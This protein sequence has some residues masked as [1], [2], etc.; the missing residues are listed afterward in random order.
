MTAAAAL[1]DVAPPLTAD[2]LVLRSWRVDDADEVVALADDAET[3]RWSPSLRLVDDHASALAWIARRLERRTDWA[4]CDAAS[5]RL[6][7]RIGLHHHDADDRSAE[8][9]YGVSPRYRRRGVARRA[10]QAVSAYAFSPVEEAGLGLHRLALEHAVG[11]VGSCRTASACGYAFEG[12]AREV[13]RDGSG[14]FDD[15]HLHGRLATDPPGPLVQVVPPE[16]VE[17]AAGAYQLTVP[18][19][20][21]DAADVLAACAD[22]EIRRWN[23]GPATMADARAWCARRGDW[24]RGDHASWLVRAATS[25]ELVGSVSL[26]EVDAANSSCEVGYWV[27][28]PARGRGAATASIAAAARF[29]FDALGL[30]R[31]EIFHAVDNPGSCRAATKAGFAWEGTHRQAYRY[32]DGELHDD[33]SHGR[34]ATDPEPAAAAR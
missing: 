9:G 28:A 26:H 7:G 10:L 1:P 17:V 18:D 15:I 21:R 34:L 33:H 25:G 6:A 22:P 13:I 32:G 8:V 16:P 19:P 11:N 14:G 24:S 27:A 23:P 4:V 5:G 31:A 3:R 2:G 12:L 20:D 29:A 30:A